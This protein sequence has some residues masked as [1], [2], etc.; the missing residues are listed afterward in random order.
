[1]SF[2]PTEA[3]VNLTKRWT[4]YIK[5]TP[6]A[7][8]YYGKITTEGQRAIPKPSQPAEDRNVYKTLEDIKAN[9][10]NHELILEWVRAGEL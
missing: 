9:E 2:D 6:M 7:E 4:D 8:T 10:D 1:M 3:L 5:G